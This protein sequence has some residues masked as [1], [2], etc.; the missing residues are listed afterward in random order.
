MQDTLYQDYVNYLSSGI[1]PHDLPSSKSNF[2][3]NAKNYSLNSKKKLLWKGKIVLK[4]SELETVWEQIH[5]HS[6]RQATYEKFKKRFWFRGMSLWVR[7]K[8]KECVACTNKNNKNWPAHRTPLIPIP[9]T[10]QMWWRVHIDLIGPLPTSS[11]GNK[12]IC[13]AVDAFSKFIE[14]QRNF[15]CIL[16]FFSVQQAFQSTI[17]VQENLGYL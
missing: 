5:Q 10:P 17:P 15:Y 1:L 9:V 3:N 2:K 8:T 14:A 7:K 11:C 6:G 4:A 16:N 12:Y 13:I